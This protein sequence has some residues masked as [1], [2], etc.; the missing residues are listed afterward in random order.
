MNET[1][2]EARDYRIGKPLWLPVQEKCDWG[3]RGC[4][5]GNVD[6]EPAVARDCIIVLED[7]TEAARDAGLKQCH[8]RCGLKRRTGYGD[9][10]GHQLGVRRNEKQFP[11][12]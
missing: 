4:F 1:R 12:I 5:G 8:R 2:A 9:G 11:A 7:I 6:E 3:C 10:C